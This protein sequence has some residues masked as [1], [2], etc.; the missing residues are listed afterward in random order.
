MK[1]IYKNLGYILLSSIIFSTNSCT[2]KP[3]DYRSFLNGQE[4]VYP[5]VVSNIVVNPGDNRLLLTWVPNSDPNVMKYIVYW[6][7]GTDSTIVDATSY[8]SSDTVKTYFNNLDENIYTFVVY[9][10]NTKGDKSIPTY[11]ENARV[12]GDK[13]RGSLLNRAVSGINYA[14]NSLTITWN[15]P[16]TINVTTEVQYTNLLN[17]VKTVYF[18]PDSSRLKI[19]DW[20]FPTMIYYR[21]SYKPQRNAIDTFNVAVFDSLSL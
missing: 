1:L 20:K 17:Q 18:Q 11:I 19:E 8:H 4:K 15:V 9:S 12:Y 10:F 21:S 13:Y 6:N 2:K 3:T 14:N 16:D 7:N 5:G